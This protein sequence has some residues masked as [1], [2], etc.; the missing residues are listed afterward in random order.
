MIL[1]LYG[2]FAGYLVLQAGVA[3]F[4]LLGGDKIA[5]FTASSILSGLMLLVTLLFCLVGMIAAFSAADNFT[6]GGILY[7]YGCCNCC[8]I[9]MLL[10]IPVAHMYRKG[11]AVPPTPPATP[12]T[13]TA[14]PTP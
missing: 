6:A 13:P 9:P 2:F 4:R 10:V 12:V 7:D 5:C 3:V 14:T 1:L 11:Y 8:L